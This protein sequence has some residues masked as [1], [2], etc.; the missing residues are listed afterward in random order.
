M[1]GWRSRRIIRRIRRGFAADI[2]NLKYQVLANVA[3][4]RE[5]EAVVRDGAAVAGPLQ[6]RHIE[7]CGSPGARVDRQFPAGERGPR[8]PPEDELTDDVWDR[9]LTRQALAD[10]LNGPVSEVI[11]ST[12]YNLGSPAP[13]GPGRQAPRQSGG[14]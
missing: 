12:Y 1:I 4:Q 6:I 10:R 13:R 8:P 3:P 11:S 2:A 7:P 14:R 5:L 9:L